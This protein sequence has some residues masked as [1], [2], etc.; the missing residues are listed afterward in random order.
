MEVLM[1][2]VFQELIE[3][4][5]DQLTFKMKQIT[6]HFVIFH[7]QTETIAAIKTLQ[8]VAVYQSDLRKL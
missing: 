6:K 7:I 1:R 3:D 5:E 4:P 2:E 8:F